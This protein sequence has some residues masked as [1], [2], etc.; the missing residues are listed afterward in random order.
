MENTKKAIEGED[1]EAIKKALESLSQVSHKL[2]E[3]MYQQAG[4][5]Q[6]QQPESD[7]S[8]AQTSESPSEDEVID[9]EVVDEDKTN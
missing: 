6:A 3:I 2:T 1:A 9:A 5:Q 8:G 4:A 7:Q